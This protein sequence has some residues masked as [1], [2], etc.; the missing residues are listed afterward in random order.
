MLSSAV[1]RLKA[2]DDAFRKQLEQERQAR[3]QQIQT[4]TNEKQQQ[5]EQANNRV[6]ER[7]RTLFI[8]PEWSFSHFSLPYRSGTENN[9][10]TATHL[11]ILGPRLMVLSKNFVGA[12]WK[13]FLTHTSRWSHSGSVHTSEKK[14]EKTSYEYTT[15]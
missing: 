8:F 11:K 5:I 15:P 1:E 2:C 3:E 9:Q 7:Q 4:L 13:L 6:R 10:R 12:D 14:I